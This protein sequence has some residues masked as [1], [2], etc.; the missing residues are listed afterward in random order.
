MFGLRPTIPIPPNP[1][2]SRAPRDFF[3]NLPVEERFLANFEELRVLA[4]DG[5]YHAAVLSWLANRRRDLR[6]DFNFAAGLITLVSGGA[7]GAV[8]TDLLTATYIKYASAIL[9]LT[10]G[11]CTLITTHFLD[12]DQI[13]RLLRGA[14]KFRTI[15]LDASVYLKNPEF[16]EMNE[17]ALARKRPPKGELTEDQSKRFREA[18]QVVYDKLTEILNLRQDTAELE[19]LVKEAQAKH[20][21][22]K[23]RDPWGATP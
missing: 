4:E 21:R 10:G 1:K 7:V 23:A 14:A 18:S 11:L 9:T 8:V 15:G 2:G 22:A 17:I 3:A 19:Q 20:G 12:D 13:E 5:D 6:R 16:I